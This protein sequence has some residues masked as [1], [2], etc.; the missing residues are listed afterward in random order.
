MNT[1]FAF[2]ASPAGR[3]LRAGLGLILILI[4]SLLL[5]GVWRWVLIIVGLFPLAAGL[6]DFCLFAPL[7]RF[8]FKGQELRRSTTTHKE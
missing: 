6:F 1:T 7:L 3:V 2:L 5:T 4:G 8:P